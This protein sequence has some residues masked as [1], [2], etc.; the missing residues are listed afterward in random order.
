MKSKLTVFSASLLMLLIGMMNPILAQSF[1]FGTIPDTQNLSEN[2][3]DAQKMINMTSWYVNQREALNLSFVASLGDM[4]QWGDFGQWQRVRDAYDVLKNNSVPYAPCQ[5]NHDPQLDRFN[6]Y[7]PESE[8]IGTPTFGGNFNGMENAYYLF[9]EAGM[10]FIVVVLQSHDNYIG[11][12]DIPSINWANDILN[13]YA[14]RRAI[15]VTHDFFEERGLIN[16]IIKQHDNLFLAV[17]GH[18]CSREQ[19]WTESSPSGNTV[20]CIMTDYQCDSDKGTTLRYYTFV[21]EEN[22]IDAFTYNTQSQQY[23]TDANSQFS[24]A[25]EM[26][27]VP[28]EITQR[29]YLGNTPVLPGV[30]EAENYNEG[31]VGEAF[32]DANAINE[33]NE[34]RTDAVDIEIC[35]EGGYNVG[36]T[37]ANEFLNYTVNVASAGVY[38]FDFRVASQDGGGQ[39]HLALNGNAITGTIDVPA[40]NGWQNWINVSANNIVLQAGEQ[41]FSVVIDT[42]GFNFNNFT[43]TQ[44]IT[45]FPP[46]ISAISTTPS[47]PKVNEDIV[48]NAT[49]T[50]EGTVASATMNWGT[51]STNLNQNIALIQSGNTFTGTIPS[52]STPTTLYYQ[53]TAIDN[54]GL[55]TS[56]AISSLEITEINTNDPVL[57][58]S[59]EFN[60]TGL[61][62]PSKWGYDTGNGGFGNNELQNY[63]ESRLENARVENGSLV[64]EARKDWYQNIEYSSAR[65]VTKNKGDWLY[66]RIEVKAKLPGA[67]RGT[68]PAIWMLPTDWEYGGWPRSGEI[69]I[70]E[71]VGYDPNVVH[72]T[73]HTEAYNHTK[74][75]QLAG[76][77]EKT[78][79]HTEYHI[80]AINWSEDKIDFF[81]DD[82]LYFTHVKHGGIDE[83]PF[84]K[85]FHLILNMA[86]GGDWG[87][88]QGVDSNIW[89]KRMEVDYVRVYDQPIIQE[90]ETVDLPGQIEAENYSFS[91]G[92]QTEDCTEGTRNVSHIDAGDWLNYE[93][94]VTKA[95]TYKVEYRV[96]SNE[97]NGIISL[98][99]NSGTT[100]LGTVNVPY[101]GGWQNWQTISHSVQLSA[102][103]QTIGIG[104][105][106]GGYNLNWI[107]FTEEGD[108]PTLGD[109]IHIEAESYSIMDGLQTEDCS[110]GGQ[111]IG[112]ITKD[113]WMVFDVNIP[114][115]S[116]EVSYRAASESGGGEIQL[117]KAG[118]GGTF[119]NTLIP[120]TGGWQAWQTITDN[121]TINENLD[122][123][124]INFREGGF[125][126]NWLRLTP[127]LSSGRVNT[128]NLES[129]LVLYPNPATNYIKLKGVKNIQ[130]AEVISLDGKSKNIIIRNNRLDIKGLTKGVYIIKLANNKGEVFM[131]KFIKE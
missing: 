55:S 81:I 121:I 88:A 87:G 80:F 93:V 68:W 14:D 128:N 74:N 65:L 112:W 85:R 9:S 115:G 53:I 117:E 50:D 39:F 123:I 59:D 102:G 10:D 54:E 90:P 15:F 83:W 67:G 49:I 92:V 109:P 94:N 79:Y 46:T 24:I 100:I 66:G 105:P 61:P 32:S 91:Q 40:S 35:E 78:N 111:N 30:V 29:A 41:T 77:V 45:E 57:V 71:N 6:Q 37:E 23:E 11:H 113:D 108:T 75:T 110:E 72:G 51:S 104:V 3:S 13:Q 107:K 64:I 131:N 52:S 101:T 43:A 120:S 82:E 18:S 38:N 63:T 122:K 84:D 20:H 7:F 114:S 25:Y 22:R 21:P 95:A 34:Y 58:W 126:L 17:C 99:Q 125:N 2:S 1:T 98:E 103:V 127:V 44:V 4:T 26:E 27:S 89:P 116:Y 28:C 36:W 60:Y 47:S 19:Y 73:V 42:K 118:G 5:G 8:F 106:S 76:K 12:Y 86:V 62:D 16:D 129:E 124:A 70:M 56:S 48:V 33:G 96:A 69:D 31:C 130:N 97:S 119:A